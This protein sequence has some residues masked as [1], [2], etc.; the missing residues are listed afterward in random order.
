MAPGIQPVSVYLAGRMRDKSSPSW[1]NAVLGESPD[2]WSEIWVPVAAQFRGHSIL[3]T[4]PF[5]DGLSHG[6]D[7]VG[8]DGVV[9]ACLDAIR[10]A[11]LFFAWLNDDDAYGTMAEL[12]YASGIGKLTVLCHPPG[13]GWT[14]D[15]WF[16]K[17]MADTTIEAPDPLAALT[18]A[19][20][21][22]RKAVRR[23]ANAVLPVCEEPA[24][25]VVCPTCCAAP[26]VPC[27]PHRHV[28]RIRRE[29]QTRDA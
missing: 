1:R 27:A 15:G 11:D 16:A 5:W 19:L 28:A 8:R 6:G 10:K 29:R 7:L 3:V 12:G 2:P 18:L 20:S 25:R 14:M 26:G 23:T 22:V 13:V 24:M 9:D 4:G 21:W 17:T